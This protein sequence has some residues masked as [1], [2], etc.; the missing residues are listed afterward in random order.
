[1]SFRHFFSHTTSN[2]LSQLS[3]SF[4]WIFFSLH[5]SYMKSYACITLDSDASSLW[6]KILCCSFFMYYYWELS[7][8]GMNVFA[9]I[10]IIFGRH[11]RDGKFIFFI[12][13]PFEF[14][15]IS[16]GK[17]IWENYKSF[18]SHTSDGCC[19]PNEPGK[20]ILWR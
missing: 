2:T 11:L 14:F 6:R 17:K 8:M 3:C 16:L 20:T 9:L 7:H 1:M 19:L 4:D 18:F 12:H 15:Y 13:F 5:L 10:I